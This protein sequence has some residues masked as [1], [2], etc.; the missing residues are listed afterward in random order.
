[1]K[2]ITLSVDGMTCSACSVGLEKYL[3]KQDGIKATS[4]NLVLGTATII[5]DENKLTPDDLDKFV[6]KAGFKS[7]GEF[8]GLEEINKKKK[9]KINLIIFT[10]L[11]L[12]FMYI[13]MGQML[14]L[15]V[16]NILSKDE[17]PV[18]YVITIF[19]LSLAFLI[20][21]FD[22]IKNGYKNAIHLTL[23]MDTLITLG[24]FSSFLYSLYNMILI[25]NGN[26]DKVHDLYFES[27]AMVIYFI[28]L[29]RYF[30][31]ISQN[32]TKEAI[33]KLVT[34]TPDKAY[35]KE[36]DKIKEITLDEIKKDDIL[37]CHPGE[38]IAAD[39][40]IV[41][42][43]AHLDESFITGESSPL[44][45]S[46]ND[47]VI[48]GSINYDGYIEYKAEKFGKNSAIS[49]IVKLV[50]EASSDKS[51]IET[52][53][54]KISGYFVIIVIILATIT[55]LLHLL[56]GNSFGASLNYFVTVLVVA[57]PCSLGL[58]TPVAIIISEGLCASHG[59]VIKKSSAFETANKIK[60]IIFDKTGT[61]T[62]GKP[63]ISEIINYTDKPDDEILKLVS[64]AEIKSSHPLSTAFKNYLENHN[65]KPY[66]SSDFKN[67][68]GKG[69]EATVNSQKL[70]IG[71]SSFLKENKIKIPKNKI[72]NNTLIYVSINGKLSAVISISD[73]IRKEAKE[74]IE[75]LNSQ[76]I[77][78]IMLT[79]DNSAVA[80]AISSS[81]NIKE[82]YASQTPKDKAQ[83]I[84][85]LKEKY[86][87]IMM[88]GDGINDSIAL[89]KADIGLSLKG[90][91]DIAI[92][93]ADVI[94]IKDDLTGILNLLNVSKKT[95]RKIKQNL[96]WAFF[97]NSLMI[98]IA[99]GL[100]K[101]L[102]ISP[103]IASIAMMFSSIFVV[104][105]SLSLNKIKLKN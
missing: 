22:I 102:N 58:A 13:S 6:S 88:C 29:G 5:Y 54:D 52:L 57:C 92:N 30:E 105:N 75:K 21:G 101:E 89:T 76:G 65:L 43:E 10:V 83:V 48:T 104:L 93:C 98:P 55:F 17:N 23:N 69:I 59:L 12:I 80:K 94:L 31:G 72:K 70:I 1:M 18:N 50:T 74:V 96:F 99:M 71:S 87:Y 85:K 26:Y 53:A 45:K 7:L 40:T 62:Y 46:L 28:K 64:S 90:A 33:K 37:V 42:G 16:P 100:V 27:S 103:V 9:T 3:N 19:I 61:L 8:K 2:K 66:D 35:L 63:R 47:K 68:P 73:V 36:N 49:E 32:K 44:K 67:T 20:Y 34:V 51:K 41:S 84:Q 86:G 95:F 4:V 25:L 60:A 15:P 24:V 56:T 97:Y 79:G 38:K 39:G 77:Q 14:N 78:T 91:S 11:I 81:L 82:Y